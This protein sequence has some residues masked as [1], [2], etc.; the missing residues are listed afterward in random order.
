MQIEIKRDSVSWEDVKD[1]RLRIEV[2]SATTYE[3]LMEQLKRMDYFPDMPGKHPVWVLTQAMHAPI[4]SYYSQDKVGFPGLTNR[5]ILS[6][7]T[8]FRLVYYRDPIAWK[9]AIYDMYDGS[10]YA[11][12]HEGWSKELEFIGKITK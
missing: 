5:Q 12:W 3:E 2:N 8:Q 10:G 7:G 9:I 1:H 4:M 11:L 6:Y